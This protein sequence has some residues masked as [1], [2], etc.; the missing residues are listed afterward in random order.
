M[1]ADVVSEFPSALNFVMGALEQIRDR[2][3]KLPRASRISLTQL[4]S[5]RPASAGTERPPSLQGTV[6][7]A[8]LL[9]SIRA[10]VAVCVKCPHLAQT[11]TQTV[12]GVGD[13]EAE[14]MF[15]GEA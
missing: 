7:K 10:R 2:G 15:I 8:A 3:E 1:V 14:L 6:D 9:E 11:R 13:P 12:F 5:V 4:Q